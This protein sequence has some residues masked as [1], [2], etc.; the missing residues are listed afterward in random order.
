MRKIKSINSVVLFTAFVCTLLECKAQNI[1]S[2]FK[3]YNSIENNDTIRV[4]AIDEIAWSYR[5]TNPDSAILLANQQL[6]LATKLSKTYKTLNLGKEQEYNAFKTLGVANK[7]AGNYQKSL[8]YYFHCLYLSEELND[9]T[10]IGNSNISIGIIYYN[11]SNFP[12]SLEYYLKAMKLFESINDKESLGMCYNNIGLIYVNQKNYSKAIEYY[13]KAL[14]LSIEIKDKETI[15]YCYTYIGSAYYY[16]MDLI[17]AFEN[18]TKSLQI[19][20]ETN[21]IRGIGIS[22][23]NLALVMQDL[24]NHTKALDYYKKSL[25][26]KYQIEDKLGMGICYSNIG[27]LYNTINNY[28]LAITYCDSAI[29][30]SKEIGDIDSERLAY[31]HLATSYSRLGKYKEAYEY[32]IKFKELTDSIFN[33]DNSEQMGDMKT[34]FE[35]EKKE[36]E[37]KAEQNKKDAIALVETKRK[38]SIL[39]SVSLLGIFI[40]IFSIYIFRSLRIT[41]KQKLIIEQKEKETQKQN[42]TISYQKHLVEEKHKEITDS[43]NYAERIQRSFLASTDLLDDNLNEYFILFKPK[44]VVSGDFYWASKLINGDFAI[45]TADSTGHGVPGAIMSLLNITSLEK[46]I[47]TN[48]N[49]VEILNHTRNTIINRL[50]KDGSPE[51]GKDGMDCS[52]IVFD[53]AQKRLHIAAANNPVWV[54]KNPG[55]TALE[56]LEIKPDKMPVGKHD[57]DKESFNLK[58]IDVNEGDTIYTLTDGYPDQFGGESGKKFMS[59]RL[60]ELIVSNS[61]LPINEQKEILETTFKNWVG[62]LEQVDDVTIIGIKI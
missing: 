29:K 31:Q 18:Y 44:D 49:P 62:N 1:D 3:I 53:R 42:E 27:S 52:L 23:T 59:K 45:V 30:I 9:T 21:D 20:E 56:V 57:R 8:E 51:G 36:A 60:R 32:H 50:K 7:S 15:G 40:F 55:N 43:I 58:T 34:Q 24:G 12:K 16:K 48:T 19:K 14:K 2:L 38:N 46:A 17:R 11:L 35:V 33:A 41:R 39:L 28:K 5:Y 13:S 26:I 10:E 4:K 54:V 37:I 47:E 25:Q 6:Q 22:Y 61:Q